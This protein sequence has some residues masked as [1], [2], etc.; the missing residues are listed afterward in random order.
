MLS[1]EP[2]VW[3]LPERQTHALEVFLLGCVD[4]DAAIHIQRQSVAK[5]ADRTDRFG[6]LLLCEHPSTITIGRDGSQSEI[7]LSDDDAVAQQIGMHRVARSGGVLLHSVGQLTAYLN[8]PLDRVGLAAD[9]YLNLLGSALVRTCAEQGV[10]TEF[11]EDCNND[12]G[13]TKRPGVI[14]RC[15]QLG[16]ITTGI[17][18]GHDA[19]STD[20]RLDR[21][22]TFGL[23]LN[24]GP[25]LIPQRM[26]DSSNGRAVSSLAMHR[27]QVI[28]MHRVRECLIRQL[29][30]VLEYPEF[31]LHT[32]HPLLKRTRQEIIEYA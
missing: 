29:T 5:I 31:Y 20:T 12:S 11:L 8:I 18:P 1:S 16:W 27:M 23:S 25:D 19:V 3:T 7:N 32:R 30:E 4:F 26:I 24:V 15:G 21:I 6:I 10:A 9:D 28:P 17:D 13:S 14:G 22:T 2:T